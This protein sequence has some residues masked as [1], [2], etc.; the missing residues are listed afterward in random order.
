MAEPVVTVY[1]PV[2]NGEHYLRESLDSIAAQTFGSWECIVV[3]DGSTDDS[4]AVIEGYRDPRFRLVRQPVNMNVAN[5]SNLALRL[6]RGKYL[7]RLDQDDIALPDRLAR[8]VRFLDANP[9]VAVCGGVMEVFGDVNG[10]YFLPEDDGRIKANL[11]TG[12]NSISNPAATVRTEFL[13]THRIMNDPRFPLSCD[14]GMWV[15]CTLAGGVL[16]NPRETVTRYRSHAAQ[17]S[18]NVTEMIKGVIDAKTRLLLAWF[19][20][21]TYAQILAA[22]PLIRANS[23]VS[24]TSEAAS[25]GIAACELM[26]DP[27]RASVCGEDRGAVCEFLAV[28]VEE[29][30]ERLAQSGGA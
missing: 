10:G 4:C 22:E 25:R 11:L 23:I 16:R 12:M 30:R 3:D 9:D 26:M 19:S 17:G 20:D 2:Y 7:A 21:L 28:R 6:A 1:V 27:A 14:Y 29:W 24:L 15:D 18:R 13:R 8:Q 5:A